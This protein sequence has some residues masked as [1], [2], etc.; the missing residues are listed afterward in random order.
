MPPLPTAR[1]RSLRSIVC[2]GVATGLLVVTGCGTDADSTSSSTTPAPTGGCAAHSATTGD[3]VTPIAIPSATVTV[4][5]PGAA[6]QRVPQTTADLRSPQAVRLATTSTADESSGTTTQTVDVPLTARFGCTDPAEVEMVLGAP[7]SSEKE[8]AEQLTAAKDGQAGLSLGPG[9]AP[10]S[11]RLLPTSASTAPARRALE[12]SFVQVMQS[13]I[14]V[15][16]TAIG[17]GA[18]WRTERTIAAAV[19]VVQT[20]EARLT[21]WDGNRMT[22]TF[23]ADESPVN[24]VFTI[25]GGNT[26]LTISRYSYTGSGEVTVDLTRPLPVSGQARY[27]GARELVGSDPNQP[28]LQRLGFSYTWK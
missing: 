3:A 17:V 7:T 6:P 16:T 25:P 14:T 2:A 1:R 28:L 27:V 8:L 10:L 4:T 26:T 18:T 24:S 22:I 20:I 21:R 19:T 11:L 5:N 12:Q 15:P 13:W 9:R 23:T